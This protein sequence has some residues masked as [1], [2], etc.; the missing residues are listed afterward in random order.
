MK[1]RKIYLTDILDKER[2]KSICYVVGID[3]IEHAIEI[4]KKTELTSN[5]DIEKEKNEY[6]DKISEYVEKIKGL[7]V[8]Y[9]VDTYAL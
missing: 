5:A 8:D 1:K 6:L 9:I 2:E 3:S 4:L 7:Y